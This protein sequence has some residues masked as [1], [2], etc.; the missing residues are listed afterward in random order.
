MGP[1]RP[2]AARPTGTVTFLFSDIEGSTQ[3]WERNAA[4]MTAALAR[5]DAAM[6]GAIGAHD[7]HIFKTVGDAFCAAFS[8]PPSAVA[9]ALDAQL[10]I[11]SE[12]WISVGGL[13][14]RI[15]L[16]TGT[17]EER[18][19]DYFGPAVNRVARILSIVYGGQVV[20]SHVTSR[21]VSESMPPGTKLLG[22]GS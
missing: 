19:G 12:D 2:S 13:R 18:D 8:D 20:L 1:L 22:L 5:H 17:S 9:A 11:A 10:R 16:H 4:A 6:R 14:V 21:L 7:G 3:R 15:A